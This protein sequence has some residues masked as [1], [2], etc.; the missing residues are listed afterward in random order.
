M[1]VEIKLKSLSYQV[2]KNMIVK[3]FRL[4][5]LHS[6][7]SMSPDEGVERQKYPK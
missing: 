3:L 5:F 4:F 6:M 7:V 1:E 2:N